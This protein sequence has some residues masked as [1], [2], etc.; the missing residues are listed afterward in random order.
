M[1][2]WLSGKRK[3]WFVVLLVFILLLTL[4]ASPCLAGLVWSG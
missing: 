2:A 1:Q 4:S 3:I